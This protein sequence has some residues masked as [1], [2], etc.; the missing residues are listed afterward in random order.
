MSNEVN[1]GGD[2]FTVNPLAGERSF[3]LQ[4]KLAPAVSEI[5]RLAV[6]F[7]RA[8]GAAGESADA[9]NE[10]PAEK[11][12]AAAETVLDEASDIIARL[13]A[14]LGPDLQP[15]MRELLAGATM[16]GKPLYGQPGAG[17]PIDGLM[18]GRTMDMWKLL[19][20]AMT[21]SYPDF[22]GLLRAFRG[23]KK[24]APSETPTTSSPGSAGG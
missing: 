22:F 19:A 11:M 24:A 18:R 16:N 3:L 2:V 1:I 14:K 9:E 7:F 10:V 4:P 15:I 17:N 6:L 20:H 21:V 5:V 23:A 13:C 12:A 8:V